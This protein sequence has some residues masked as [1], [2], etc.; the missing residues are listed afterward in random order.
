[1]PNQL[2]AAGQIGSDTEVE[3]AQADCL[4]SKATRDHHAESD[5]WASP[6]AFTEL[7]ASDTSWV[8]NHT[9]GRRRVVVAAIIAGVLVLTEM[10]N[11]VE[12]GLH[13]LNESSQK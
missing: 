11:D 2:P 5:Q 1:L 10:I 7:L 13:D 9:E 3:A 12:D 6:H 4:S 8:A